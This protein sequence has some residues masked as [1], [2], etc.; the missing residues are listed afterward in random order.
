MF[1]GSAKKLDAATVNLR[2]RDPFLAH[3]FF[4]RRAA[5][6]EPFAA[7]AD[8]A[9]LFD[10]AR[11]VPDVPVYKVF[12]LT[13]L[14]EAARLAT[15][16]AARDQSSYSMKPRMPAVMAKKLWERFLE[17]STNDFRP[18]VSQVMH[19]GRS[20]AFNGNYEA[21]VT[22][23]GICATK[24]EYK[25]D[26]YFHYRFARMLSLA[27]RT[28]EA[29]TELRSAYANGFTDRELV[30]TDPDL[31]NVRTKHVAEVAGLLR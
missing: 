24:S 8:A 10:R 3:P 31:Q 29:L 14:G 21:A 1:D 2:P 9:F 22:V 18:T 19:L 23:T 15:D 30:Q 17:K 28:A 12:Q 16:A 26:A 11:Y 13:F 5:T 6:Q 27:G 4:A 25:N 7:T 20:H